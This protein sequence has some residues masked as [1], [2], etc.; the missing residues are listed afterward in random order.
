MFLKAHNGRHFRSAPG[1]S[2]TC[3]YFGG[4]A[5]CSMQSLLDGRSLVKLGISSFL[6]MSSNIPLPHSNATCADR[7][8]HPFVLDYIGKCMRKQAFAVL[9]IAMLISVTPLE[10]NRDLQDVADNDKALIRTRHSELTTKPPRFSS[11]LRDLACRVSSSSN[12]MI[13]L[14]YTSDKHH[15]QNCFTNRKPWNNKAN[16][17]R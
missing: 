14:T 8:R 5:P 2:C 10:S 6:I 4:S 16:A 7:L 17:T 12:S 11:S 13:N 15:N 9:C 3:C 1:S